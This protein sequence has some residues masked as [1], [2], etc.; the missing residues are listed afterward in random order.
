MLIGSKKTIT[1]FCHQRDH[2]DHS[3]FVWLLLRFLWVGCSVAFHD[4]NVPTGTQDHPNDSHSLEMTDLNE[5]QI[6]Q[7]F[8]KF[9]IVLSFLQDIDWV[10]MNQVWLAWSCHYW[11]SGRDQGAGSVLFIL[12][13]W[14]DDQ[15]SPRFMFPVSLKV[16]RR[17]LYESNNIYHTLQC[18]FL[19]VPISWLPYRDMVVLLGFSLW[20]VSISFALRDIIVLVRLATLDK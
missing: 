16:M 15:K 13:L 5:F 3:V 4:T 8:A 17:L 18:I 1:R 20:V 11:K 9:W 7:W 19:L 10:K 12:L 6:I 14:I 2:V